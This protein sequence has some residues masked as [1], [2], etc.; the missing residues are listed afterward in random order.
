MKLYTPTTQRVGAFLLHS[1]P[2]I[3]L[4]FFLSLLL[5]PQS[6]SHGGPPGGN[7]PAHLDRQLLSVVLSALFCFL[8][9]A[10]S[11]LLC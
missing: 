5:S 11:S 2:S 4:S 3:L 9:S 7:L 1:L 8:L 10:A 6:G